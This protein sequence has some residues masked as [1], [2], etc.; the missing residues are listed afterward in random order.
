MGLER[1]V[2]SSD[3]DRWLVVESPIRLDMV[4]MGSPMLLM[5][6]VFRRRKGIARM[7]GFM[8]SDVVVTTLIFHVCGRGRIQGKG[9]DG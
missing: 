7:A 1:S 3:A 9:S 2:S 4:R 8:E 5:V 6:A